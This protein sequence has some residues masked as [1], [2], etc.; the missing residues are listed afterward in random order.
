[1]PTK[2]L[3]GF[4]KVL[5]TALE[6]LEPLFANGVKLTLVARTDDGQP[7]LVVT[8]D[9]LAAVRDAVANEVAKEKGI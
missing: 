4:A 8:S 6:Q 9:E 2:R 1:M 5:A 7:P 3:T